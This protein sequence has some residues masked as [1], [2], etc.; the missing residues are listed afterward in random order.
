[1]TA[2]REL[3]GTADIADWNAGQIDVL[4]AHPASV[5]YGLNLQEGGSDGAF[6]S[7]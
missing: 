2:V 4:L 6:A 7:S 1:M 3:R 5:A